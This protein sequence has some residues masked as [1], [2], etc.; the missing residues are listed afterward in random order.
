[1]SQP[2]VAMVVPVH[3]SWEHTREFLDSVRRVNYPAFVVIVVDDGSTDGTG[4][5]LTRD[6]PEVVCLTGDGNLW[7][8]GAVNLGIERAAELGA[9]Y[10]LQID[11]DTVVDPDFLSA[12]VATGET[13]PGSIVIP[14]VLQ[15][16]VPERIDKA[17]YEKRWG[18][19]FYYPSGH[20][21]IDRGQ[22]D[23]PKALLWA[24]TMML[25]DM[26]VIRDIGMMDT[27]TFPMYAADHDFTLRARRRGHKIL[28]EP[29]SR[30]WHKGHISAKTS[31]PQ[32]KSWRERWAYLTG[33]H[34]SALQWRTQRAAI[35]RHAPWFKWP[36]LFALYGK[37]LGARMLRRD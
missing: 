12:L 21:E 11:N 24:D 7:S 22:Y 10:V 32:F 4:E 36:V 17:G 2:L 13:S 3:N 14:K 37:N 19:L 20:G 9:G 23:E 8:S 5:N 34:R 28:Y 26:E 30:L 33:N 6:Y 27:E 29:G 16:D 18:G 31:A 15:Y 35:L 1:M 25:I